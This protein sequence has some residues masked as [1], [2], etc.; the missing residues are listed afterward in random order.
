MRSE[1]GRAATKI[2]KDVEA[3]THEAH[4]ATMLLRTDK[5]LVL[6][7]GACAAGKST[8]TR[9]ICGE[10]GI[11]HTAAFDC[12]DRRSQSY[13]RE[14]AKYVIGNSGIAIAGNWKNTSDA[15]SKPEALRKVVDLCF[16]LAPTVIVDSFRPSNKFVDWMQQ[17]PS[18][19]LQALFVYFDIAL[20]IN[21]ARLLSRRR[22]NGKIETRLPERTYSTL[23]QS[24]EGAQRVWDYA[25]QHYLREPRAFMN[26]PDHF[27]PQNSADLVR[28]ELTRLW[29]ASFRL[30]A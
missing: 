9:T 7:L 26:I 29:K 8:L 14:R 28:E 13:V 2:P 12:Y 1:G 16:A 25:Q 18:P 22:A 20:E 11:E 23:L 27:T 4:M 19:A 5:T 30:T 3:V 15:I 6:V 17:H 24:R 10:G 21:L